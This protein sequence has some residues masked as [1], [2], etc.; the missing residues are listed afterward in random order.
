M[1]KIMKRFILYVVSLTLAVVMAVFASG[2][3][4]ATPLAFQNCF[5][6]A[7]VTDDAPNGYF[8]RL[9]FNVSFE[10]ESTVYSDFNQSQSLKENQNVDYDFT[11]GKYTTSFSIAQNTEEIMEKTNIEIDA[12]TTP[13]YKVESNFTVKAFY[14][15]DGNY[16]ENLGTDKNGGKEFDDEIISEVYFL[17]AGS[18]FAP[19]YSKVIQKQ[20]T[21]NL[22]QKADVYRTEYVFET[23]YNKGSYKTVTKS[24]DGQTIISTKSSNYSYRGAID[25]TQLL[26]AIRN[27]E[28]QKNGATAIPTVSPAYNSPQSL[29]I[30]CEDELMIN[31]NYNQ[32]DNQ[33]SVKKYAIFKSNKLN[34]GIPQYALVQKSE[35]NNKSLLIEYASAL[36]PYG[37]SFLMMG[38]LVYRLASVS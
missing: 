32:E 24:I 16:P 38:A 30:R 20:T 2:C 29:T 12:Q 28:I 22:G 21:L 31:S 11:N 1:E 10:K 23:T 35:Q 34:T 25:N 13:I 5:L 19:I 6:G 15:V 3:Q 27:L 9:E 8:E 33:I 18:S 37:S 7:G 26:F 17:P 4:T 36:V 14:K